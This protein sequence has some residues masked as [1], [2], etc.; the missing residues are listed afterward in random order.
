MD[1][2]CVSP[3]DTPMS[4]DG[5]RLHIGGWETREGWTIVDVKPAPHVSFVGN[6]TDLSFLEDAS[7][8][9]VYASHVLEHLGYDRELPKALNEI[10]R[11]LKTN[12]RLRVSVPDLEILCR[13]FLKPGLAPARRF[14]VMRM[15]FGGRMDAHDVHHSGLTAEFLG[16]F[17]LKAGFRDLKRV[18][19]FNEFQDTSSLRYE[20]V[21]ISLNMEARK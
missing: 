1:T 8:S 15:M 18:A 9:E 16:H 3:N 10:N 19:E 13:L 11:V 7:C 21:L 20:G 6:C 12:G 17:M 5:I 14:H 4:D 2:A